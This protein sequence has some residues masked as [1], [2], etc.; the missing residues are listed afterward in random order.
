M[1]CCNFS[2]LVFVERFSKVFTVSFIQSYYLGSSALHGGIQ[3]KVEGR[4]PKYD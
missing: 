1:W 4:R 3:P 2:D